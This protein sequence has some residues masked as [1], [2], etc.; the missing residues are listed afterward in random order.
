MKMVGTCFLVM[1]PSTTPSRDLQLIIIII[2]IVAKENL[3]PMI[4]KNLTP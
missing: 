3:V 4:K 2:A 1:E